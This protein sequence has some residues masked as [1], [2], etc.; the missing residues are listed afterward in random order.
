MTASWLQTLDR[1]LRQSI[2]IL[3]CVI[4]VLMSAMPIR[5]PGYSD[6]APSFVLIVVFFWTLNRPE[7]LPPGAL[8]G[9]GLLD[10]FLT[11]GP[12]GLSGLVLMVVCIGMG[13][14]SRVLRGQPFEILW[15][16]FAVVALGAR[17]VATLLA[18][19]WTGIA[20]DAGSFLVAFAVTVALYPV[21]A[22]IMGWMQRI[23]VS[24]G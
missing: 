21:A 1:N 16:A 8:F 22:W 24:Q 10:D 6:I 12:V 15:L 7:L 14:Q 11:G 5:V 19:L 3:L 9:I 4:A 18:A 17:L 13:T 20:F 23:V 2:P